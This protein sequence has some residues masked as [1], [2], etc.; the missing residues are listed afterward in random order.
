[1]EQVELLRFLLDTLES[2]RI[3]YM[4]VGSLAS[5]VF[6]QGR[7]THDIDVVAA[8]TSENIETFCQAF[9]GPDFYVSLPAARE[10]VARQ[11]QFNIIHPSSGNKIDLVLPR[12]DA[13]GRSQLQR[14]REEFILPGRTG[15]VASPEDVILGKLW[16]YQIGEHDKHLRDIASMLTV[17]EVQI[18]RAYIQHWAQTLGLTEIWDA[19]LARIG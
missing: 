11:G 4:L 17:G 1:M 18:D 14:R 2:Q 19:V 7:L 10:A 15:F 16:Y 13:W 12:Q 3:P 6:G 9:P 8:L 5:G